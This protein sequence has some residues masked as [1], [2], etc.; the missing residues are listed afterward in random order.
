MPYPSHSSPPFGS[1][2]VCVGLHFTCVRCDPWSIGRLGS[3]P[4]AQPTE[5]PLWIENPLWSV[6]SR[7]GGQGLPGSVG[8]K[9]ISLWSVGR[10]GSSRGKN[11]F[12]CVERSHPTV[13]RVAW[14]PG[15]GRGCRSFV[16]PGPRSPE[17]LGGSTGSRGIL[18]DP[19]GSLLLYQGV[20]YQW[21]L[22]VH[23]L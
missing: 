10:L 20:H 15:G 16:H 14:A 1:H 3:G 4:E 18:G 22:G 11:P 8:S 23:I 9:A 17:S 21:D 19:T 12:V 13:E 6:V 2:R 5:N 7:P